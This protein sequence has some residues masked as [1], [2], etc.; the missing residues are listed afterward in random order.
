MKQQSKK[1][2]SRKPPRLMLPAG[3]VSTNPVRVRNLRRP[4][5]PSHYYVWSDPPDASGDEFLHFVSEQRRIKLKGHSFR[6]FERRVIPLLDGHHTVAD[7]GRRVND[8]FAFADLE[9]GLDV[10]ASQ[11]LFEDGPIY[12]P[13]AAAARMTPQFN[14]FHEV[15]LDARETRRRLRN[16]RVTVFG[17]GG[18]GAGLVDSL[19]VAGIGAIR[20]VDNLRVSPAD[21]YLSSSFCRFD[22]GSRRASVVRSRVARRSPETE[23]EIVLRDLFSDDAVASAVENSNFVACCLDI[24][25]SSVIHMLNRACLK[26]GI[27][28]SSCMLSGSEVI[29]GPTVHP[30]STPCY[31]CFKMRAVASSGN[32]EDAFALEKLLNERNKDDS[33]R[34]ENLVFGAGLAANMLALET[35]REIVGLT[36]APTRG[37]IVIFD[38][39]DMSSSK[40]VVLRKP[41]CP[42]CFPAT[43][44][45]GISQKDT[46]RHS[47]WK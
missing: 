19:A 8:V 27:R 21:V 28:W 15:G 42:A 18:A 44:R 17:L 26:T 24:G 14:F 10:L 2:G 9:A 32:P 25:Q 30:H 39:L 3:G 20:C 1:R 31:L 40:H 23:L 38:L 4:R 33:A 45:D 47:E 6:E 12:Q 11:N 7:I 13:L 41:W 46:S 35:L 29:V 5:L 37:K 36:H 34:G 43:S 16:A 22:I